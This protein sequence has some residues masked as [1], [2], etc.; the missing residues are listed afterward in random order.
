LEEY[1]LINLQM[2]IHSRVARSRLSGE[3][4]HS[5]STVLYA[6]KVH[7]AQVKVAIS[8]NSLA[9]LIT[10]VTIISVDRVAE[11]GSEPS[12]HTCA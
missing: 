11:Y 7:E 5:P 1:A 12:V 3:N 2:I 10:M 6:I 8:A 4:N 9:R